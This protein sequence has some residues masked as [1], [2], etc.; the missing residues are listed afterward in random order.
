MWRE[1]KGL[2]NRHSDNI[3]VDTPDILIHRSNHSCVPVKPLTLRGLDPHDYFI[4]NRWVIDTFD[5]SFY[6][7]LKKRSLAHAAL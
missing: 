7:F 3:Y 1:R 6:L 4:G 5:T 2:F